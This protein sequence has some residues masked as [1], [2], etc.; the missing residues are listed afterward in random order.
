MSN[1]VPGTKIV[2]TTDLSKNFNKLIKQYAKIGE[3]NALLL[4]GEHLAGMLDELTNLSYRKDDVV[5]FPYVDEE[6]DSMVLIS[7]NDV[8]CRIGMGTPVVHVI[9]ELAKDPLA[10]TAAA[11]F[12]K[13]VLHV[14]NH[15][16]ALVHRG[17]LD[18]NILDDE[19]FTG[20]QQCIAISK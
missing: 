13:T 3:N 12:T 20:I 17:E 15:F 11:D 1:P 4:T 7:T 10:K 8:Q 14:I 19:R 2:D 5:L 16:N 6:G 18:M 9:K